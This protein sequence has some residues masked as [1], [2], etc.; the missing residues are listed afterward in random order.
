MLYLTISRGTRAVEATTILAVSD[1]E[2]V[3]GVLAC[4]DALAIGEEE[5]E[6]GTPE[7]AVTETRKGGDTSIEWQ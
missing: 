3:R 1:Q 5:P 4:M 2:F 6:D 7:E